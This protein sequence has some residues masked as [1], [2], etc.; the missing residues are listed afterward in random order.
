MHESGSTNLTPLD[1]LGEQLEYIGSPY[2]A[3]IV[4][5]KRPIIQ[6]VG[7]WSYRGIISAMNGDLLSL[8]TSAL[9]K[10]QAHAKT[11]GHCSK[12]LQNWC[13]CEIK[14]SVFDDDTEV[15]PYCGWI[16]HSDCI[17]AK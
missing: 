15:C 6:S 14:C 12:V 8:M 13:R 17:H 16:V 9:E 11:C 1:L 5:D 3:V 7:Y 2:Q 4:Y 10:L